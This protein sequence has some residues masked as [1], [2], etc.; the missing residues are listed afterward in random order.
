MAMLGDSTDP[1]RLVARITDA[2]TSVEIG[3]NSDVSPLQDILESVADI[4]ARDEELRVKL[5]LYP[6]MWFNIRKLWRDLA[7]A[8]LTFWDADDS[9]GEERGSAEGGVNKQQTLRMMCIAL[10]KFTRNITANVAENQVKAFDNEPDIR[11]LLHYHT[12]WS[13]MEDQNGVSVA[14]ILAQTL[15]NLVTANESLLDKIWNTYM[16]LPEDQVVLIRLLGSPDNRTLFIALILILNCIHG[17]RQRTKMLG[18]TT[19]GIRLCISILDNMVK[20]Y[21]AEEASEGAQAFDV[22]YDILSRL[23]EEDLVPD[24]YKSFHISEEIITPH[25]T[26]LLKIIDSYLQSLHL[27]KEGPSNKQHTQSKLGRMLARCF[28]DQSLYAQRAIRRALGPN[29]TVETSHQES[30][31]PP[32][33]LDPMLP[34]VC[35]GLVL[36]TQCIV[37]IA[38]EAEEGQTYPSLPVNTPPSKER[39]LKEYFNEA[40]SSD[41]GMAESLIELLRLLDL[42][43]PRINFGKPVTTPVSGIPQSTAIETSG[44]A[45]LKRDLVRLLGVLCHGVKSVQDR[46]RDSG[47]IQVV[48]NLCVVDERNPSCYFYLH[49]LLK[50]NPENQAVVDDIKPMGEWDENGVLKD[51]PGSIRR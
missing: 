51:T 48:M 4:L 23:I 38:L 6:S 8:Q 16:K 33:E 50:D 35:E 29:T 15:S 17:S 43:L 10:S 18:R 14:R 13:A 41:T 47:G 45:Y 21:D 40:R 3:A 27:S 11:R 12:S 5:G 19:I 26:T 24:L 22:S 37:T 44:F 49:S 7:R 1:E 31:L 36:V 20:L 30:H 9:D 2:C 34:K 46:A 39:N 42:F 25:Q 28:F 32:V